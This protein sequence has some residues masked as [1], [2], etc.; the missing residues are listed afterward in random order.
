M[1]PAHRHTSGRSLVLSILCLQAI[2]LQVTSECDQTFV[3]RPGGPLNGTFHAP[4]FQNPRGHSRQCL[5]TFL[6]GPGQRVEIV[7]TSF[8]LRGSPPDG[9]AVGDLPACVHEY[10]DVYSEVVRPEPAELINSPFGGRYCGPI[11]PRRRVSLYRAVALAFYTDKNASTADLFTGRF[12]FINDSEYQVGAPVANTPCSFLVNGSVKPSG[13]LLSPTYPGAYPK[14]LVCNYQFLG[15][16]NQRIRLEFRDF[17]LFYGGPHCPFDYVRVYDGADNTSA[18]VGTYCGQQRNLVL[19]SSRSSL[20]VTFVTLPRTANTQNR[21]FKGIFEFANSF[22]KLDFIK[23]NDGEHIRGSEC[24]QKIL[25]KKESTGSVYSPNYPFPYMP[26]L[27]CRYFIYGMQDSQHL[28]RVRLEFDKFEI[29]KGPKGDCSEGYLKIY[30]KGQETTDS[31]DKFDHELCGESNKTQVI[32]SE[33]PRMV[34]VFSSGEKMGRGFKANYTFETEYRIPGTAAPDGSCTFTYRSASKKKGEFNSPRYPSNYP[35]D[36]NCTYSF[37]ATPNE[38]VILIFENFKVRAD[39]ANSTIGS[40]GAAVCQED[41]LEIFNVYRDGTE[42][43]VGRFCGMTAPGPIESNRGATGLKIVLHADADGVYSGFKARYVFETAKSIFGDCGGNVSSLDYGVISSPNFPENYDGPTKGPSSKTCNWYINVRPKYKILLDFESFAVEGDPV[44]RGCPAA[45]LRLWTNM[46]NS[47]IELC[48][49]KA[50]SDKWQYLSDSNA[51]RFSFIAA[52]KAVGAQGFRAVWTEVQE[53]PSCDEFQ[54]KKSNFCI[55]NKLRCN[56]VNN[57]GA[58][59]RTDEDDCSVEAPPEDYSLVLGCA[60]AVLGV[61]LLTLCVICH[62]KRRR[63]RRSGGASGGGGGR[64]FQL[65]APGGASA[66]SSIHRRPPSVLQ[67]QHDLG[68]RYASVDS[69]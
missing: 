48:G 23:K 29:P 7:F 36:T 32:V 55:P 49:E 37:L 50:P 28:E 44:G 69:V 35:S 60:S 62:R 61:V 22:T 68:E 66:S 5:Y 10:M 6:A 58:S 31:Y 46:A 17:D 67:H 51:I 34:L 65:P 15:N 38:Q 14:A 53:G 56:G 47:P 54:C 1:A 33:G 11:P 27:V 30:T 41:W 9:S 39:S 3:S 4:E 63:R 42:R 24:D 45:V 20:L 64:P 52:D 25:S 18:I 13:S 59:D 21:G 2:C 43:I 16:E 19:Y 12:T 8:G 40:Y 26:K 57:C